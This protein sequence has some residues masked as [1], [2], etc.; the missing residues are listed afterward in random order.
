MVRRIWITQ[1]CLV[2]NAPIEN[3]GGDACIWGVDRVTMML[4]TLPCPHRYGKELRPS[5]L[6]SCVPNLLGAWKRNS[7]RGV[8]LPAHNSLAV[9]CRLPSGWMFSQGFDRFCV[10]FCFL[11]GSL[12]AS[13]RK[14]RLLSQDLSLVVSNQEL[15][16]NQ[17][18]SPQQRGRVPRQRETPTAIRS[19]S[20]QSFEARD[21]QRCL[22]LKHKSQELLVFLQFPFNQTQRRVGL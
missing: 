11:I 16:V 7:S 2:A 3:Q 5:H 6:L 4:K 22:C 12:W 10:F 15:R 17:K 14:R 18:A 21:V 19:T 1:R 9:T 8:G 13:A 20:P